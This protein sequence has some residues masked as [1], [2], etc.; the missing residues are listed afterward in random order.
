MLARVSVRVSARA[1]PREGWCSGTM[2]ELR[3]RVSKTTT[4]GARLG[5]MIGARIGWLWVGLGGYG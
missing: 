2:A 4:G 5:A 1:E 3:V